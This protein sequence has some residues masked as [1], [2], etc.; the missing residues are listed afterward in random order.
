MLQS[1]LSNP[2]TGIAMFGECA[3]PPGKLRPDLGGE[4]E[5]QDLQEPQSNRIEIDKPF[6]LRSNRPNPKCWVMYGRNGGMCLS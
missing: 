6:L 2:L 1:E 5:C 4:L 3:Q